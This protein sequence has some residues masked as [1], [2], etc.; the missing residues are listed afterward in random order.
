MEEAETQPQ[1]TGPTIGLWTGLGELYRQL[2][3]QRHRDL[4]K[5][6]ALMLVGAVAELATIG[7]VIPFLALLSKQEAA[8]QLALPADLLGSIGPGFGTGGIVAT[9]VVFAFFAVAAGMIRLQLAWLTQNF[10]YRVGHDLALGMQRR[11]L[12]QPYSFHIGRHSSTLITA[13]D[14]VE[15]LVFDLV[16]PLMQTAIAAFIGLFLLIGLLWINALATLIAVVAFVS[17]YAVV[18]AA[19]AGRRARNSDIVGSAYHDRLKVEQES[20]GGIRDVIIDKSQPMHL[21]RFER[22]NSRLAR[23]RATTNFMAQAPRYIVESVGMIIVIVIAVLL[24][25]RPGG[26]LAALPFLG[27]L[28]V[29]AQRLLPLAQTVYTGWSLATAH[30]S[31]VGQVVELSRLPLPPDER[32]GLAPLPVKDRI[33]FDQVSFSYPSRPKSRAI[34]NISF[35]IGRGSMVALVGET[36]GGKTTLADL[37]MGLIEPTAGQILVDGV[38]LDVT[39]AGRWQGAIAHVPQSIFLADATIARNIALSLPDMKLDH[40]RV[41]DAARKAQLY[42]FVC[43]LPE[44]FDTH[45]GERGIRLSGGQRQRLGIARAIYKNTPILVFDEATSALDD[46]TE[47]AVITALEELRREGRTIIIVAHRL[48]TIRRCDMV[49]RLDRGRLV[50]LGGVEEVL[51]ARANLS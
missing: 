7:S 48:S 51:G 21:A 17:I 15:V 43:S 29:G 37:L 13:T 35:D 44:G 42:D 6:L 23:A 20:L 26:L 10:V 12:S 46:L 28:A 38:P 41:V 11:I 47:T 27:A 36:G 24:A 8:P 14:K 22:V 2:S 3:R 18:S 45:V 25:A 40:D 49:A 50:E 4:L 39:N 32:A 31:I 9:A 30:R 19:T 5:L 16:L 33:S 1:E 34:D